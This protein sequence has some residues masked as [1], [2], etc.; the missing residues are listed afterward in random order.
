MKTIS[1]PKTINSS[2]LLMGVLAIGVLYVAMSGI[3]VPLLSNP[4][5]DLSI[6]VV[7]GMAMCAEGGIG[8]VAALN[9]WTH[10]LS[11]IGYVLGVLI[12]LVAAAAFIGWKLPL[13]QN[14]TEALLAVGILGGVKVAVS[15]IHSQLPQ[16]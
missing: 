3:R 5:V 8:R 4:L 11:I 1:Q 14:P 12:L 2:I 6:L 13:V 9:Q 7:I 10:P 15:A 16:G